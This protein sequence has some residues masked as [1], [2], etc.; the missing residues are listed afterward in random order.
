[1]SPIIVKLRDSAGICMAVNVLAMACLLMMLPNLGDAAI[2]CST[3]TNDIGGC[4]TYLVNGGSP[5][6]ACCSGVKSLYGSTVS[7]RADR[8]TACNCIKSLASNF[9]SS[10]KSSSVS[11]LPKACGVNL[12]YTISLSTNCASIP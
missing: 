4:A 5:S 3:V 11:G 8:I 9:G 1:M 6:G 2:S 10:L 7:S 12:G